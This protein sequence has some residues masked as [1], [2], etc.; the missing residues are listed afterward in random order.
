MG[1]CVANLL[2]LRVTLL[3]KELNIP[4]L[5]SGTSYYAVIHCTFRVNHFFLLSFS[6]DLSFHY[7]YLPFLVSPS[8]FS[9]CRNQYLFRAL[10]YNRVTWY[11]WYIPDLI[12]IFHKKHFIFLHHIKKRPQWN[13]FF[14][15]KWLSTHRLTNL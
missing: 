13:C 2:P 1:I 15:R 12:N 3:D 4:G 7:Y 5:T 11:I 6:H 10:F 14:Y 8:F 9:N